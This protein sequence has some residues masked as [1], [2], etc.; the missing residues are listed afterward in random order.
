MFADIGHEIQL[1]GGRLP[2]AW[3]NYGYVQ[4][5]S[6]H[7]GP[8][9][10]YGQGLIYL[11]PVGVDVMWDDGTGNGNFVD[12]LETNTSRIRLYIHGSEHGPGATG[13]RLD[14][15]EYFYKQEDLTLEVNTV[16]SY[17]DVLS[18][19]RGTHF[20]DYG[21]SQISSALGEFFGVTCPNAGQIS[22]DR[23]AVTP[24]ATGLICFDI[25]TENNGIFSVTVEETFS[26]LTVRVY[27]SNG[28]LL[29]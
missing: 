22:I 9:L 17:E 15:Y 1:Q 8:D 7:T 27:D 6:D 29:N 23:D 12:F 25:I 10:V 26:E 3:W 2:Y 20:D 13:N 28:N 21:L 14:P 16:D 18:L 11:F 19:L 24:D 5:Q 4:G